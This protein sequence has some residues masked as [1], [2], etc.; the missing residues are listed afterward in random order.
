MVIPKVVYIS[1]A[2][3]LGTVYTKS[4]LTE[5]SEICKEN[6]LY[7]YLDGARLSNALTSEKG[8]LT[9]EEI[10]NL[11]DAFYIGG[12]KNGAMIG[13][14]L[15]ICNENLKTYMRYY[16]KQNG[17]LL[18]K[19][20]FLGIQFE[21]LMKDDLFLTIS[22]HTNEMARL[23]TDGFRD[24]RYKFVAEPESNLIFVILPNEIDA[25]LSKYCH[26]EVE[27]AYDENNVEARFV[28][29]WATP[30]SDVDKFLEILKDL[31]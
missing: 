26:Y 20:R 23:L 25:K 10:A 5:I 12:T 1:N 22:K 9:V 6:N 3:E 11:C 30:K 8:D 13:E 28:T 27:T 7:L 16:I 21:E 4:E 19:G 2:T 24:L 31:T 18:A 29:S 17:A 14:A 15:V